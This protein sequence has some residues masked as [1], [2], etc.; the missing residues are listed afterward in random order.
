MYSVHIKYSK[1]III[2]ITYFYYVKYNYTLVSL[3]QKQYFNITDELDFDEAPPV[4]PMGIAVTA[5]SIYITDSVHNKHGVSYVVRMCGKE[6]MRI[7]G[8]F[9]GPRGIAI[10]DDGNIFIADT[11]H[12]RVLK[13]D[14]NG[15]FQ[16]QIGGEYSS[17]EPNTN[18]LCQPYALL[19][20]DENIYVCDRDHSRIVVLDRHH[21]TFIVSSKDDKNLLAHPA[22]IAYDHDGKTFYVVT[23]S[24]KSESVVL[25]R[26]IHGR[27]ARTRL[28]VIDAFSH[29]QDQKNPGLAHT[30]MR[31]H[32]IAIYKRHIY[33]ADIDRFKIICFTTERKFVNEWSIPEELLS[34]ANEG[35][36]LKAHEGFL[37][38]CLPNSYTKFNIAVCPSVIFAT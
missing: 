25:L 27:G 9:Q 37:H 19:F 28:D 8:Y 21:L 12:H 29:I 10:D 36:V 35:I 23:N 38:I 30:L 31:L 20:H 3:I 14:K 2:I 11:D 34:N 6:K 17:D 1:A 22:D 24:H 15:E 5:E 26:C 13:F 32:S 4:K 16:K 33:V 18:L 7:C